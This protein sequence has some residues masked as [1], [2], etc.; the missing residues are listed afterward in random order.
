MEQSSVTT[1]EVA[2]TLN[3]MRE[4]KRAGL[5]E[6]SGNTISVPVGP[7][8]SA[9]AGE[10]LSFIAGDARRVFDGALSI[11]E[12]HYDHPKM[13]APARRMAMASFFTELKRT[14][15]GELAEAITTARAYD[16]RM[17]RCVS[18]A[19]RQLPAS[20]NPVAVAAIKNECAATAFPLLPDLPVDR[21]P[22]ER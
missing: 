12:L 4:T 14:D 6:Q 17:E 19:M 9:L 13:D 22:R 16:A 11:W 20:P 2:A 1:E 3:A 7:R 18:D 10:I 8:Q 5:I 15:A 21:T